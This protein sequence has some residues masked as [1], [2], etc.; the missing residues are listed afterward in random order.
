MNVLKLLF[1]VGLLSVFQVHAQIQKPFES[2]DVFQLEYA[3]DPQI[4]PNGDHVVYRRTGFDIMK[5]KSKGDLWM[6]S[7][8]EEKKHYKLTGREENESSARWSPSGDRIAF[9]S[10]G[11]SGSE[12]FVYWMANGALAKLT[13]L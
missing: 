4:S 7:T 9:V 11:D 5:D 6:V 1:L 10:S 8:S 13:Q 12:I 2:L 3:D